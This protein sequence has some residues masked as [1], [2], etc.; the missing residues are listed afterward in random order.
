MSSLVD[1]DTAPISHWSQIH[2]WFNW[3]DLQEEA[4]RNFPEGS[5]FVEVGSYLGRSLCSLAEVVD[6]SE[7]EFTV[8]GVD[9]CRGS[10]REGTAAKDSHAAAVAEGGGTL[11]G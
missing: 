4:V 5:A 6:E 8:V 1:D 11:A 9:Y 2:G 10:G 3:R 7:R